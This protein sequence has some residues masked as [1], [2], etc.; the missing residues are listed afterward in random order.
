MQKGTCPALALALSL[1]ATGLTAQSF[2]LLPSPFGTTSIPQST[3]PYGSGQCVADFNGDGLLDIVIAP[4]AGGNF[5]L[6][7]NNGGMTF[8][9]A[10]AASALGSH[11]QA[12]GLQNADVDNDG[13]QDLYVG[14]GTEPSKLFINDGNAQFSDQAVL[15]GLVHAEDNYCASFGDYDRDGWVDLAIANRLTAD[16]QNV[17]TNRLYRNTGGG[18]FMDVTAAAGLTTTRATFCFTFMDFDEDLWPDLIEVNDKGTLN[19]PNELWR[20]NGDGTFTAVGALYGANQPVD[21]MG[22]DFC[23]LFRDGGVDFYVTDEPPDHLLQVWD[24]ALNSYTVQTATFGLWGFGVGWAHNFLDYD[25]DGWQDLYVVHVDT[26]N[27]LFRNPGFP[28]TAAWPWTDQAA[29]MGLAPNLRQ[30]TMST[31]DFD[32]DGRIDILQRYTTGTVS[33]IGSELYKNNTVGGSWLTFDLEGTVSNRDGFGA[34][35]QVE[36]NGA[37]QRQH[38]RSGIGYLSS[39]DKRVHFG[40]GP[41]TGADRV[42]ITWPSGQVQYMTEVSANQIVEVVEPSLR[43]TGPAIVGGTTQMELSVPTDGNLGYL[44]LLSVTANNGFTL[45]DGGFVPIDFDF[46]TES[47]LLPGNFLLPNSVGVLDAN[48]FTSS[49]LNMPPF[50]W[51]AGWTIYGGALTLDTPAFPYARTIIANPLPI[52]IQ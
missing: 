25:N 28:V 30:F 46:V 36:A 26:P 35:V 45:P 6:L 34:I 20:N 14:G 10:S 29:A 1:S 43:L 49:P 42:T 27:M 50:P 17:S 23:D 39:S 44:M 12:V 21:G 52:P 41:T 22:I 18:Y 16:G 48:G 24:P 32:N 51:L 15:R 38:C 7:L 5:I 19:G 4:P 8:T 31:A 37:T 11:G 9:D 33:T 47:T 40:L 3:G 13:D 2:Q